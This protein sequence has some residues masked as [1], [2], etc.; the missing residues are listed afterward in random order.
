MITVV[1]IGF[2]G[3]L[4]TGISPCILPVLPVIFAAGAAGGL[5]DDGREEGGSAQLSSGADAVGAVAGSADVQLAEPDVQLSE[6]R[7]RRRRRPLAVVGGLVLSFSVFTLIGSWLLS[8]LGLP[9]DALRWIGLIV[10]GVVG[11]GLIVPAIGDVLERPFARVAGGRQHS[12][13]GG[14]VLGLS[15]G[16]VFVPCAGPVLAAIT[17]VGANHRFG[18]GAFLLTVAF[19]LGIAV[20]LLVFALLGQRLGTRM[21]LVRSQAAVARKVIGAVLV[22][23]AL[24]IGANL[25]DGLQRA[26]PGYTN[27]LQTRIEANA[28]AKQ[29]LGSVTGNNSGGAIASCTDASATL[30]QCGTAPPIS[31][32]GRWLN[33][34]GNEPLSLRGL[35]GRVV[36]VDFWTYSCINCQRTLPHLEAWNRSYAKD[37]LTIIGVH[38][39]EFAFE[40]VVSNVSQAA[41]QLGVAYPIAIDNGYS[42]WNAYQ[43]NYWPAEYLVDATG[44][45]RHV[46]F[47]EGQYAQSEAF[48]RQ[49]LLAADPKVVLPKP[50]DVANTTP[51]EPTTPESYLGYQHLQNLAGETVQQDQMSTYQASPSIPQDEYAYSGQWLVGAESST[52]GPGATLDLAFRAKDVYLVLGGA[53]T[54]RV[55]VDG[56]PTRTVAVSGEPKLYQLVGSSSSQQAVLSLAVSSG[57]QAYDFTFG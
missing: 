38:T 15:L 36:L 57:V 31:G 10:L 45:V 27:S 54:I 11:L 35:R 46:D 51:N 49:L 21:H 26:L 18:F 20:P 9:Q 32:I 6:I 8:L 43:N 4:V 24:V 2:L 23:T 50:T 56:K 30:Q 33:T 53:G 28:S 22:L 29:A 5:P 14:F 13:S 47:G 17:V 19:A 48:I 39:P 52:A 37:G 12:D 55:S 16:L 41:G 25:T 34:P 40:H 7:R 3:G 1:L 44:H 42:T